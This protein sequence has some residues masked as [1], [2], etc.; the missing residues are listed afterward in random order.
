VKGTFESYAKATNQSFLVMKFPG[1]EIRTGFD[2]KKS[3]TQI[4]QDPAQYDP[5][6]KQRPNQPEHDFHKYLN[7]KK[8][9]PNAK[10]LGIE[11]VEGVKAYVVQAAWVSGRHPQKFFFDIKTGLLILRDD[12]YVGEDGVKKVSLMYYSDYRQVGGVKLACGLR[13]VQDDI[14]L[15]TK[16]LEVKHNIA[17]PDAIFNLPAAR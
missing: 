13:I 15:I 11:E 9:Y 10:V 7:F 4:G 17:I 2:G 8:H 12:G 16:Y 14:V 6:E 5:P 1:A 3:W